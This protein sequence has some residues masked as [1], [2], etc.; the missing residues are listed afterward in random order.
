MAKSNLLVEGRVYCP[1]CKVPIGKLAAGLLPVGFVSLPGHLSSTVIC[2][3][4]TKP[5]TYRPPQ[6]P[7]DDRNQMPPRG[8]RQPL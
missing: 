3:D 8:I 7:E 1:H 5:F 2:N 4:C 6:K